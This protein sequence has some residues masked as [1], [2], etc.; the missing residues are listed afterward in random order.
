MRTVKNSL[1]KF[2]ELFKSWGYRH[3]RIRALENL[4]NSSRW[5]A[6]HWGNIIERSVFYFEKIFKF[7]RT[8]F[9]KFLY[10]QLLNSSINFR[11]IFFPVPLLHRAPQ[12]S[13]L[14]T[15]LTDRRDWKNPFFKF[16]RLWNV[17]TFDK[18][19]RCPI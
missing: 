3:L 9:R 4:Q 15:T 1:V 2:I 18:R 19:R 13:Y 5:N 8:R 16:S 6:K 17:W 11:K 14:Q 7:S 12:L 10:P